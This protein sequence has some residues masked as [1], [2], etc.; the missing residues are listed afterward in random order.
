MRCAQSGST[1]HVRQ[2]IRAVLSAL[3]TWGTEM[4]EIDG[5]ILKGSRSFLKP[6][7]RD[8]VLSDHE[9]WAA[10]SATSK[11]N[12]PWGEYF[13]FLILTGQRRSEVAAIHWRE[14]DLEQLVWH[15]PGERMKNRDNHSVPITPAMHEFLS[16][17]EN[18]KGYLFQSTRESNQP[19]SGFS[20]AV[21][22]W[23]EEANFDGWRLHD[24]RRTVATNLGK[25]GIAPHVIEAVIG[26]R[27]GT[28][29]DIAKVY[30]RHQYEVEKLD[31]LTR[32][33]EY[34]FEVLAQ[35]FKPIVRPEDDIML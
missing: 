20:K 33:H 26:H 34:L 12:S 15:I 22:R 27:S 28:I 17:A 8:R 32:W 10:W 23:K 9:L 16:T 35:D 25:I 7:S 31:A 24:L 6:N 19:I 29:S 13:R 3:Y 5:N 18:Q 4:G 11:L 21:K 1:E 2:K 14:V 30:N